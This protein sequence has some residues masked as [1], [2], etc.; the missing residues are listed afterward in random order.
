MVRLDSNRRNYLTH[1]W[2]R[3]KEL[4]LAEPFTTDTVKLASV[5]SL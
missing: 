2:F 5:V 4:L 1:G 3:R